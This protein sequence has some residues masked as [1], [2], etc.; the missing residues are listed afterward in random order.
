MARN[1]KRLVDFN[2]R[3]S[4]IKTFLGLEDEHVAFKRYRSIR[5]AERTYV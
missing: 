1:I 2:F 5:A 4:T 3:G